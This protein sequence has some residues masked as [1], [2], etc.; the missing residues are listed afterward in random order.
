MESDGDLVTIFDLGSDMVKID[1]GQQNEE[2]MERQRTLAF[3]S[4]Q[5]RSIN[6]EAK[7]ISDGETENGTD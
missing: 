7:C 2:V 6:Q 4:L 1:H 3:T 5:E